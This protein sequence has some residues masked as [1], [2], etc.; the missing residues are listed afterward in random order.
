MS[1]GYNLLIAG[2]W[3]DP[4]DTEE[5]PLRVKQS[6][7]LLQPNFSSG[8]YVNYL[9]GDETNDA[10]RN[11]YGVVDDRSVEVKLRYDPKTCSD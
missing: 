6:Y 3:V 8:R 10:V 11:K 1:R 9:G 5:K 7:E 2:E 4:A